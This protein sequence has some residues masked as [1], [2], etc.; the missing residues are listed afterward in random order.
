MRWLASVISLTVETFDEFVAN[1]PLVL[2]EFYAPWCG[3]CKKLAPEYE[4]A[5]KRLN[6]LICLY[7]IYI[8]FFYT[9][10]Y[11]SQHFKSAAKKLSGIK[12]IDRFMDKTD[13]TIIGFFA[14]ED[15]TAFEAFKD[16]A[17]MLREEFNSMGFT[18]DP[19]AFKKYDA[20]PNDIIIFYPVL[21]HS[22]FEP[23]SR[24]YN[25]LALNYTVI[26]K[27]LDVPIKYNGNRSIDHLTSFMKEHAVKSF[28]KKDEL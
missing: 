24:T 21:F 18:L 10:R 9:Y 4:K 16:S 2:V 17:E 11:D 15:S 12:E 6:V 22:K 5:A 14:T 27:V 8:Y 3:H 1:N 13:V 25:K 7:E 23:K 19:A 20:K 26:V 28:Q